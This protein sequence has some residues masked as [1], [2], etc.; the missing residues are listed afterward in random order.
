MDI[1]EL[2][3]KEHQE[4]TDLFQQFFGGGTITRLVNKVVGSKPRGRKAVARRIC[5]AL[6]QHTRLEEELFYPEVRATGDQELTKQIDEAER[7]HAGVKEKVARARTL[8][9]DDS[10]LEETMTAIKGDV[11]HHVREEENEMFPRLRDVMS[12][13]LR[14]EIGRRFASRKRGQKGSRGSARRATA[15]ARRKA[16]GGRRRRAVART[17]QR[18]TAKGRKT[19]SSKRRTVT[20]RS[21][22]GRRKTRAT[23]KRSRR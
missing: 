10:R 16:A 7:E 21:A 5:D 12:E 15:G 23:A 8:L 6:D 18:G 11:D 9:G 13:H 2:L 4:V 1:L 3:E 22:A 20:A 14:G 17:S 19:A